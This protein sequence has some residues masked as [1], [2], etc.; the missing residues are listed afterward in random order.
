MFQ[1]KMEVTILKSTKIKS[2]NLRREIRLSKKTR[3][4]QDGDP[5]IIKIKKP[6][7][8]IRTSTDIKE[9]RATM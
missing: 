3:G 5:I 4:T 6:Q 2:S 1:T 9:R 7:P 8:G